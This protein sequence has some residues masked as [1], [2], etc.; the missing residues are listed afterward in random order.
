M[1]GVAS[2]YLCDLAKGDTVKV[3]GP[4]GASFLMPNHPGSTLLMVC[5]GTGSAPMRAMTERRRRRMRA[6]RGRS[7]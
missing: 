3:V 5:T 2:N 4:Y 1:R 6:R 7:S